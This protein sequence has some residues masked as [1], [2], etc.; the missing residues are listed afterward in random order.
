ME[1]EILNK[2]YKTV[3]NNFQTQEYN[4]IDT[5]FQQAKELFLSDIV[6]QDKETLENLLDLQKEMDEELTRQAFCEG[7]SI[8]V[9]VFIEST[10]K[11]EG[12]YL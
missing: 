9:R 6:T 7:F 5:E 8:A 1:K 3:K 12:D 11:Q 2:L 10:Y 4:N